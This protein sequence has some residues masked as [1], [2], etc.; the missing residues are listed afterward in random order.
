MGN[1]ADVLEKDYDIS[2]ISMIANTIEYPED[3]HGKQKVFRI[4]TKEMY[5]DMYCRE[6]MK[7]GKRGYVVVHWFYQV[8]RILKAVFCKNSVDSALI[9]A[10]KKAL[11]E[12][13]E[14][15]LAI[16]PTCLPFESI[17][18]AL[19][20]RK[21][22][23]SCKVIPVIYDMFATNGSI[24]R[25]SWNQKIKMPENQLLE[26]RMMEECEKVLHMPCWTPY[27]D[28]YFLEY[29]EKCVEVEHPLLVQSD[30]QNV[31][32]YEDGYYHIVYTG[33]VDVKIRN[34]IYALEFF[35]NFVAPQKVKVHFYSLGSAEQIVEALARKTEI[36]VAHG[37]VSGQE[38]HAAMN[39]ADMLFSIGNNNIVQMPSKVF[40]YMSTG[41]PIVHFY[42]NDND[43][44][45]KVLDKYPLACCLIM[46]YEKMDRQREALAKFIEEYGKTRINF[47]EVA[48]MFQTAT[49]S[50]TAQLLSDII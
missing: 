22:H 35:E 41:K 39:G 26:K 13:E 45:K 30:E 11:D 42:Y 33:V 3:I 9:K 15:P 50:H 20:Y 46:D 23:P 44:A 25:F 48:T 17:V 34:P 16:I 18:A 49:A 10:Y 6:Q 27:I 24:Q 43:P 32:E 36:I 2:V 4:H 19:E 14:V 7:N 1:L 29:K 12:F 47:D 37:Q 31:I 40:E 21:E 38:A 5:G 28:K 8:K